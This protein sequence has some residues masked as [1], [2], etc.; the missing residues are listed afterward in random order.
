MLS[1]ELIKK[2]QFE[3]LSVLV[4]CVG[5]INCFPICSLL[6]LMLM[7]LLSKSSVIKRFIFFFPFNFFSFVALA[8]F[9]LFLEMKLEK[10]WHIVIFHF[11]RCVRRECYWF[12]ACVT[13]FICALNI[14]YVK[15]KII[16]VRRKKN[17][18]KNLRYKFRNDKMNEKIVEKK[19]K[20]KLFIPNY[21]NCGISFFKIEYSILNWT[22]CNINLRKHNA[23]Y[24]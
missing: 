20:H 3:K 10:L 6:M 14:T 1:S 16:I 15:L 8:T 17:T 23:Y 9:F 12:E 19:R 13:P 7:Y 5:A 11:I 4:V 18:K 24:Y 2:C 22:Q 21:L